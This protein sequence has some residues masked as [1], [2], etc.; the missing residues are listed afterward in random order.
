MT[1]NKLIVANYQSMKHIN[2][3]KKLLNCLALSKIC[4]KRKLPKK[5]SQIIRSLCDHILVFIYKKNHHQFR[6]LIAN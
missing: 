5:Q 2:L 4:I 6:G 1:V 3:I